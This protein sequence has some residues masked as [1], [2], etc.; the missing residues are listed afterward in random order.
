MG[1]RM[2]LFWAPDIVK[3]EDGLWHMYLSVQAGIAE[4]WLQ[5]KGFIA[6]LTSEDL[7]HWK[8]EECLIQLGENTIDAHLIRMPGGLWRMYC[9]TQSPYTH[10]SVSESKDLYTWSDPVEVMKFS[11]EGAIV[12]NWKGYYWLILDAWKGQAVFRSDDCNQWTLQPG[13]YLMP[14]GSGT[15]ADDI[16]NALHANILISNDRVYMFYF[17]HPGRVGEDREKDT[18]E[19]RRTSIQVVELEL[20]AEGWLAADRNTPTYVHLVPPGSR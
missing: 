15:G 9:K 1:V 12:F 18:Y 4:R 5:V 7:L 17:T 6:H 3:G 20:N 19:Q 10:I 2:L 8:H 11:G 13:E 14:Y 16:P